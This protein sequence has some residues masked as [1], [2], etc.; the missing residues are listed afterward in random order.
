[1][2][3]VEISGVGFIANGHIDDFT[4]RRSNRWGE[5]RWYSESNG[6]SPKYAV[7]GIRSGDSQGEDPV[8][9][10]AILERAVLGAD[11]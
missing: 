10:R 4:V 9:S 5:M 6:V 1:M 11:A 7:L 2:C 8:T 3:L